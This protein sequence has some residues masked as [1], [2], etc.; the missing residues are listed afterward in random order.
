MSNTS[1]V[2]VDTAEE[3]AAHSRSEQAQHKEGD[4]QVKNMPGYQG[5]LLGQYGNSWEIR[6]SR[7]TETHVGYQMSQ[8][9][10]Q[11]TRCLHNQG[12][13][14][15]LCRQTGGIGDPSQIKVPT[16]GL[17]GR[18]TRLSQRHLR[19]SVDIT[20]RRIYTWGLGDHQVKVNTRGEL[21]RFFF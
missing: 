14:P 9:K 19:N 8:L 3:L 11:I 5:D 13:I 12:N 2:S 20:G 7:S 6:I 18:N 15:R 1:Q 21:D 4:I 10:A 16:L 17:C